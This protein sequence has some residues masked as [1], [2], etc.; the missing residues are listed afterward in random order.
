MSVCDCLVIDWLLIF[1]TGVKK[2]EG[3]GEVSPES[4]P[5]V[6]KGKLL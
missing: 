4:F 3:V 1:L 5:S 6:S 2:Q